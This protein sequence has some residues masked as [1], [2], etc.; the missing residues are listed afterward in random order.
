MKSEAYNQDCMEYMAG[1][2]DK[3]FD[4]AIVDPPYGVN[5]GHAQQG[6]WRSSRMPKKN[7]DILPPAEYFAELRRVSA[8]QI[9]FGGNYFDL[10]PTRG[11]A[12]WDKG[13]GFRDRDFAEC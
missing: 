2:P 7:W 13:A 5:I 10:P 1:L 3:A 12:V 8:N 6:K 4:L 9:V 11:F